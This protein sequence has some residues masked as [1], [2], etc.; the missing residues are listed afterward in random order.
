MRPAIKKT[1]RLLFGLAAGLGVG[2]ILAF[3]FGALI[4]FV[5]TADGGQV[6]P[7]KEPRHGYAVFNVL[8]VLDFVGFPLTG[9]V[10]GIRWAIRRNRNEASPQ[11]SP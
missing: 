7:A 11:G 5:C 1:V 2:V 4:F 8:A 3:F 9:T 10:L 6:Y